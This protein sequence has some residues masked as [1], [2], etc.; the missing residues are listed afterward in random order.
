M[1][2]Y[3]LQMLHSETLVV[4]KKYYFK[5]FLFCIVLW[6]I[7]NISQCFKKHSSP[8]GGVHLWCCRACSSCTIATSFCHHLS[9]LPHVSPLSPRL[10]WPSWEHQLWTE[11]SPWHFYQYSYS[12]PVTKN[13]TQTHFT[14]ASN[15]LS[16]RSPHKFPR[17]IGNSYWEGGWNPKLTQF[18]HPDVWFLLLSGPLIP[19]T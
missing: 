1:C 4:L 15:F 19:H 14:G 18:S 9:P 11:C 17:S 7:N 10:S 2:T 5:N 3:I 12:N 13:I 8:S 16:G 6:L